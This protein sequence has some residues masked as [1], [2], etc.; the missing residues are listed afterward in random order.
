M[1]LILSKDGN[2]VRRAF[3]DEKPLPC[4]KCESLDSTKVTPEQNDALWM[5]KCNDCGFHIEH[6]NWDKLIG[7]WN[8]ISN[9]AWNNQN[10]IN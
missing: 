4:P 1:R 3:A 2:V 7:Y 6:V 10:I 8:K 9:E 5:I